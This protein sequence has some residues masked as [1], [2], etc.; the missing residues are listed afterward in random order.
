MTICE[1]GKFYPPVHGGIETL[2]ELMCRGFAQRDVKVQC[3][4]ANDRAKTVRENRD[5]VHLTRCASFGSW[6]STSLCPG[7]VG[8][9]RRAGA[10]IW[11]TH[12]PNPLADL[13]VLRAPAD[14]KVV[15]TYH[16][17]VVRQAGLMRL[18]GPI[19]R[20]VLRRAD[21]IVV[22]TP[23]NLEFSPWLKAHRAK[24]R[25]IPFGVDVTRFEKPIALPQSIP[26]PST[27]PILLTVGRLVG[28]K[29]HRFLIE[30]MKNLHA[31]LW[32]VGGGPLESELRAL[33][34]SVCAGDRIRFFG[35]ISDA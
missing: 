1:L 12:F 26:I 7:Y 24:A 5:G 8:V 9:A 21:R 23:R 11:H 22:A 16:S 27:G 19:P 13:A 18:Y 30:A 25:I 32:I 28:Y 33:A 20:R 34:A 15:I 6:F 3:V 10:K 31:T 4:V 35:D 29:G 17:D 14:A 2:L